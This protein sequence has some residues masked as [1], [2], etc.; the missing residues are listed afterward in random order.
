MKQNFV[1]YYAVQIIRWEYH[2][3]IKF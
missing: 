1:S 3:Q 2:V